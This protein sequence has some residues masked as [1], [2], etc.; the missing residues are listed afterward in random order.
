LHASHLSSSPC[1]ADRSPVD[2]V[3]FGFLATRDDIGE[4][5]MSQMP[6][7]KIVLVVD[8]DPAML[9]SVERLLQQRD[10]ETILFSSARAFERHAD[11]EGDLRYPRHQPERRVR[12]RAKT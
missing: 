10:Y 11:F 7:R 4:Q 12:D 3:S 9:R 5:G 6:N 1:F 2:R 8:D